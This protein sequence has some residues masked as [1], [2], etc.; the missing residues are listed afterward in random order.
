VPFPG[1]CF[2][3]VISGNNVRAAILVQVGYGYAFR[4]E[5]AGDFGFLKATRS[6]DRF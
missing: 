2:K 4:K 1:R 3:P 5:I 6:G